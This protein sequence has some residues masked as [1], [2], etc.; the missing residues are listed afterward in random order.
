MAYRR[1][2]DRIAGDLI[3]WFSALMPVWWLTGLLLPLGFVIVWVLFLQSL[4]QSRAGL[5]LTGLWFAAG[6]AQALSA[7]IN[8]AEQGQ[9]MAWMLHAMTSFSVVGWIFLGACLAVG[10]EARLAGPQM[11]RAASIQCVWI[12]ALSVVALLISVGGHKQF[13][14]LSPV[15]MFLHESPLREQWFTIKFFNHE[16]FID[17]SEVRLCL[18]FPYATVLGFGALVLGIIASLERNCAWRRVALVGSAVGLVLSYSRAA[19]VATALV[20]M[21][22]GFWRLRLGFKVAALVLA[23][24]LCNFAILM[25]CDPITMIHDFYIQLQNARAGS[26]AARMLVDAES[27]RAFLKSPIWGFGWYSGYLAQ[28]LKLP[29]G[30]HSTVYG[31]LYTGGVVTFGLVV[32]AYLEMAFLSWRRL[33][34][35]GAAGLAAACIVAALGVMSYGENVTAF[36]PSL[37]SVFVFL[38]GV[39]GGYSTILDA[40]FYDPHGV[41]RTARAGSA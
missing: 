13:F 33:Q 12:L 30:S 27:W 25:G 31:T 22:C 32:A 40:S 14:F 36:V 10:A 4:P 20:L 29:L 19:F 2:A 1:P 8:R 37:I 6:V 15:G 28:W 9:S 3:F 35:V 39:L 26:T 41:A 34:T 24:V 7:M 18:F 17:E 38:G 23:A 5:T 11:V 21:I 16:D